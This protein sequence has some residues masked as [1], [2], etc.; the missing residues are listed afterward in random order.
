MTTFN[1]HV[2]DR[3]NE[4]SR[5]FARKMGASAGTVSMTAVLYGENL[6]SQ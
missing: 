4:P 1:G 3:R 5:K 2:T 6:A